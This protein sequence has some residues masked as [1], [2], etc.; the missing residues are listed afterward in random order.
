MARKPILAGNWKMHGTLAEAEALTRGLIASSGTKDDRE[1]ILG[2]AATAL[3]KVCEL[4]RGTKLQVAAQNMHHEEKGAFTGE[5]S[6]LMLQDLGVTHVII[7]HSERRELFAETDSMIHQKVKSALAH[8]LQV[9]L[10]VGET[11]AQRD[12]GETLTVV[13]GQTRAAL[14]GVQIDDPTRVTIAYEPIWAIGTGRVA[15][16]EQAQEVHKEI[17]DSLTALGLAGDAMRI[18]YGGSVKPDNVDG[19][20]AEPDIDGALVGGASLQIDSFSRIVAF[21]E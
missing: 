3:A 17:R 15:T 12:A 18:L 6:A 2:P 8:D 14:E 7:G 16:R 4:V 10:C 19:L 5:T 21:E 9:I 20:M 11:L 1:V 13:T